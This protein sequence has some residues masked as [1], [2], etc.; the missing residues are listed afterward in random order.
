MAKSSDRP[1]I[2]LERTWD[3]PR[4]RVFTAWTEPEWLREWLAPQPATA[5]LAETRPVEDGPWLIIMRAPDGAEFRVAGRY[6][7]VSSPQRL[8]FTWRWA[9][10]PPDTETR[11]TVEL[12]EAGPGRTAM[13][14]RHEGF[15]TDEAR[16]GHLEGW[17]SCFHRL[18]SVLAAGVRA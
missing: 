12:E 5:A 11:V 3:V 14:L 13:H 18:E 17:E 16:A 4:E 6:L 15:A 7:E 9:H 2:E 1:R 8:V 10:E